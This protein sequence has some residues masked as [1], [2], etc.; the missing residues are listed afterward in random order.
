VTRHPFLWGT[1]LWAASH[2]AANGD[3]ASMIVMG[4]ILALS[5]GGMKH[6]D[7]R[8]EATLG[9]AWGPVAL[10][11]STL[12]FA[13][14]ATGRTTMDW[15]GIGWWRPALALALYAALLYLHPWIAGVGAW[16]G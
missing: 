10:T 9:A 15:K 8:R 12:P 2:L 13:A 14:L 7:L 3:T 1:A 16:P 5:L 6:I 4:G 11:T